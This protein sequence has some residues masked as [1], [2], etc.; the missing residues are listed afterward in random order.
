MDFNKNYYD[1]LGV[2]KSSSQEE[3]K[4][5]FRKKAN[6][7][8]PDKHGGDDT[9]FKIINEANQAIGDETKRSQYDVKSPHGQNYSPMGNFESFFSNRGNPFENMNFSGGFNP[10]DMFFRREEFVENLDIKLQVKVPLKDVY[11]NKEIQVKYKRNVNCDKCEGTGF[12]VDGDSDRCDACDGTGTAWEPSIGHTKCR[13]CRGKGKI[14]SG[15]CKKCNGDKVV[16]RDEQ[17]QLNNV[18]RIAN[19]DTKYLGGYGHQSKHYLNKKGNLILDIIYEHDNNYI[20]KRDGLF[21]KLDLHYE[22]AIN[23]KEIEYE[24]L[25]NKKYKLKIKPK[26]KDNETMKM[27]GKGLLINNTVRQDLFILINVIIDYDRIK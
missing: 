19:N 5:A 26:T 3:I 2:D 13:F 21:Y 20:R 11:N 23:G 22:D 25:D 14:Y 7:T 9:Q 17:F 27:V 15:T 4:K 16:Q 12:D 6:E 8:H 24:H 1:I 10:F 18:Y